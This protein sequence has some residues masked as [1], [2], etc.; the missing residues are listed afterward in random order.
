[1]RPVDEMDQV[2]VERAVT[3]AIIDF[4]P[5]AHE[6]WTSTVAPDN[7]VKVDSLANAYNVGETV[8]NTVYSLIGPKVLRYINSALTSATAEGGVLNKGVR[9]NIIKGAAEAAIFNRDDIEQASSRAARVMSSTIT[10]K[11]RQFKSAEAA[12]CDSA[13]RPLKERV[14]P[15]RLLCENRNVSFVYMEYDVDGDRLLSMNVSGVPCNNVV[16]SDEAVND[17]VVTVSGNGSS[18]S[19]SKNKTCMVSVQSTRNVGFIVNFSTKKARK[20]Y[21]EY[22]QSKSGNKKKDVLFSFSA[23]GGSTLKISMICLVMMGGK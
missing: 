10:K 1:M 4:L 3:S 11:M 14:L 19:G 18:S 22:I 9:K 5:N 13:V 6:P 15:E 8:Q 20:T 23:H 17:V 16:G 7:A 12:K 21:I 2:A